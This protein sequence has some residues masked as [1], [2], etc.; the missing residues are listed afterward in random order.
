MDR[1][2][3]TQ[4]IKRIKTHNKKGDSATATYRALRGDYCLHNRPTIQA[5]AKI[6]KEFEET[7]MVINIER[8]VHYRFDHSV[9]Y[10][11]IVNESFAEN[12]NVMIPR[13]SKE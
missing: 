8:P 7:E 13:R 12:P 1:L 4:R 9:E 11:A 10:I 5:I 3:I 2:A 6:A